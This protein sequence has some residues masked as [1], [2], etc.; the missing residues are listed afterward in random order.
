MIE[1][2]LVSLG[3]ALLSGLAGLGGNPSQEA[4]QKILDDIFAN[5]DWV[6]E[7][8]FSKEE[9]FNELLP[10]VQKFYTGA[11]DIAA[12]R[13]G[14]AVGEGGSEMG[15]GQ[16]FGEYYTQ[17]LAPVI[18]EGQ[19]KAGDAMQ[20][21][22]NMFGQMDNAAKSR[23]LQSIG[24]SANMATNLKQ[25]SGW[26]DFFINFL[27]GGDIGSQIY[28]NLSF[29]DYL[30]NK[31]FPTDPNKLT[32]PTKSNTNPTEPLWNPRKP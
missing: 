27:K 20:N 11:A 21:F 30:K 12:G 31:E 9:L 6:K 3:S 25:T 29:A 13:I 18:A 5:Q 15:G 17:A 16:A 28:G 2:G 10:V 23:Y 26:Q 32:D 4:L 19:N 14:S 24:L 22:I 1:A 8:P 7:L